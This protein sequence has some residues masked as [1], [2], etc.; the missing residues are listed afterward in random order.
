MTEVENA[1]MPF[2]SIFHTAVWITVLHRNVTLSKKLS[3]NFVFVKRTVY[4]E[5]NLVGKGTQMC[6]EPEKPITRA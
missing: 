5:G 6:P 4:S 1:T 3:N 2:P